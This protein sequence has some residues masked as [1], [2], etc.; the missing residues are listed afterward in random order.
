MQ[1]A[2]DRESLLTITVAH[3]RLGWSEGFSKAD[4]HRGSRQEYQVIAIVT[5]T[6]VKHDIYSISENCLD[7]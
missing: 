4:W 2:L 3:A 1:A 6:T 7:I 5:E